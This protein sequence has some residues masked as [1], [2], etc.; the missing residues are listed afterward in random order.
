MRVLGAIDDVE[1]TLRA[2]RMLGRALRAVGVNLDFAPVADVDSNPANPVIG[3]RSFGREPERVSRH[4]VAMIEGLQS[5]GVLACAKHF[6]GHGDTEV[7]SHLDL[8]RVRHERAR[9]DAIE[10][11][12][13]RAAVG[14]DVASVMTAHVVFDALA[15][16]VP[17]TLSPAVVTDV[18]RGQLGF[19]GVCFSDDLHMK[20]VS[21]RHSIEGAAVLAI[22]A[23]C[24]GLLICSEPIAQERARLEL[25]ARADRDA[26][27]AIRLREA[28]DRMNALRRRA[29]S[30][31][32]REH[33][34]LASAMHDSEARAV[35]DEI[36]RRAE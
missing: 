19:E 20:A 22:A 7:D 27:F 1:L 2:A 9:L 11:A 33:V 35:L 12:P 31:P 13:F 36:K 5:E 6:P 21:E 14:A 28:A 29:P 15:P 4:A 24:D 32:A 23:G 34:A 17:A 30:R 8:P 3:D 26:T 16:D 25:E 10:L 18:L